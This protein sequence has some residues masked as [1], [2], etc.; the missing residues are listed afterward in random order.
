VI[1]RRRALASL[2][3]AT[4]R[5]SGTYFLIANNN[6]IIRPPARVVQ[7]SRSCTTWFA[8]SCPLSLVETRV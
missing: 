8:V 3:I 7:K 4:F 1:P 2:S 5:P 6:D